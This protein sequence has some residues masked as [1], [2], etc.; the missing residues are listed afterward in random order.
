MIHK[1]KYLKTVFFGTIQLM[2]MLQNIGC[3]ST[4][5]TAVFRDKTLYVTWLGDSQALLVRNGQPVNVMN[6][7][8]PEREVI[9]SS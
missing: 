3:G 6:P 8:K 4:A 7:H 2:Y 1:N 5:V 9:A